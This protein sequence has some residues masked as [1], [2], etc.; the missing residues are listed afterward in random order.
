MAGQATGGSSTPL[1]YIDS[2]A[3][4]HMSGVQDLFSELVPRTN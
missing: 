4:R 1:W 2:G 3:S